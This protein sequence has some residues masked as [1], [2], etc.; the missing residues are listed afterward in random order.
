MYPD[1][2]LD[3]ACGIEFDPAREE[4]FFAAMP[5]RPGVYMIEPRAPGAKPFLSRTVDLRR[6]AERLLRRPEAATKRLNLREVARRIRFRLTGSRFE[7]HLTL[8]QQARLHFPSR[9][10]DFLRLRAP[11]VVKI[12]LR[13]AYPR[14]YV[15]RR[16][17]A[18]DAMYVGP[19][20]SRRAAEF[21]ADGFRDLFKVR[22][23][24]IKIRRDPSF[25]GCIYS[26]MKMCLAPC[27]AG[28]TDDEYIAEV[29]RATQVLATS[30]A[31]LESSLER[32]REGA[33]GALDF[34]RAAALHKKIEK[35]SEAMKHLPEIARRVDQL[36][37][38]ILQR[39]AEDNSVAIFPVHEGLIAEPFFL[40][41]GE[42]SSQPRS[43][44]AILREHLEGE[45]NPPE[46]GNSGS[47][48]PK[49]MPGA[50]EAPT[51]LTDLRANFGLH[52]APEQLQ[53]HLSLLARWFY[54]KPR[55][56][57]IFY[58]GAEWP[59]RRLLR[60]CARIL[61]PP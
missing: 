42:L 2:V 12:N 39:A 36:D 33:S 55:E 56:G 30:G 51:T 5:A 29:A 21:F 13:N 38:V 28:C 8:Y 26:E 34:E 60:A 57:E 50:D 31:S 22:R 46:K 61:A 16:I 9:Y 15:T 24:Q 4:E 59:Y 47:M 41:F 49:V 23:C 40:R 27:Y 45:T 20:A 17:A 25:P 53:E 18:D 35:L 19:F 52:A 1:A 32:E 44:E 6:A 10:R 3:L 14:F 48:A 54:A 37:A 11:A 43:V 7:Q 58:R